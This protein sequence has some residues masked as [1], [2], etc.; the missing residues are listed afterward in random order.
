VPDDFVVPFATAAGLAFM[1]VL[2]FVVGFTGNESHEA[3]GKK[4]T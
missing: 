2:I 3:P 1:L 4:S